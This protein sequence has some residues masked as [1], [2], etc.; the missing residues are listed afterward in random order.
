M[1]NR[2][3]SRRE[4]LNTSLLNK[5][6][7]G[8]SQYDRIAGYFSTSL[9]DISGEALDTINGNIR[10]ICNAHLQIGDVRNIKAYESA[11]RKDWC[12]SQPEKIDTKFP[13]RLNKLYQLLKTGK[14]EVKVLPD[15]IF[16][17]VHGKAGVITY[18][19]GNKTSFLGSM[20]ESQSG[21]ER[22]YE[23]VWEDDST[24]AV[25]W[26]QEEFNTLWNNEK[27][28]PLIDFIIEDIKRISERKIVY[29]IEQI[30]KPEETIVESP[31]Y[32]Q[33]L[34]LWEHQK[35]FI[36]LVY[37]TQLAGSKARYVLADMVGLGKTIQLG[38]SAQVLSLHSEKPVLIICPKTLVW[39]WQDEL[40]TLMGLPSA[41]W[42]GKCWV[43]ESG[44]IFGG[45]STNDIKRCPRK[46]GIISQ[47]IITANTDASKHL[48]D[49]EFNTVI[50]DECHRS[51]RKNLGKDKENERPEPNNLYAYL[52]K[53]AKKTEHMLMG[54]ATPIQLYPIEAWDLLN[55]LAQGDDKILGSYA[56]NWQ[57][58]PEMAL[59]LLSGAV[60]LRGNEEIFDWMRNPLPDSFED[61]QNIGILRESAGVEA[62][63]HILNKAYHE[64]SSLQQNIVERI[65]SNYIDEHNPFIRKIIRRTRKYLETTINP[66]TKEPYLA[67]IKVQLFGEKDLEAIVLPAYLRDAYAKAEEFSQELAKSKKN[68]KFITSLLLKRIGSSMYAGSMTAEKL[69]KGHK[70]NESEK[71]D[72]VTELSQEDDLFE[73]E[74][75]VQNDIEIDEK[76]YSALSE[77]VAIIKKQIDQDPKYNLLVDVLKD[78]EWV[79]RGC[80]IFSQYFDTAYWFA[81]KIV[82]QNVFP[83]E[84]IALYAGGDK[85]GMF[86]DGQ[87]V[88]R[89]KDE[90]KR[91]VKS[92]EIKILFGTDA[93]SEGLNLQTLGTLINIDLPW[94]PTRLEQ[95]KGRIQ[96]I[97]QRF[98]EVWIYNMRYKDSIEDRVHTILSERLKSITSIFGQ[99]PDVLED[100]WVEIAQ[101]NIEKAKK[102]ID[103]VPIQS[104]FEAK[105]ENPKM[106]KALK[107]DS[108]SKVIDEYI[109]VEHFKKSWGKSKE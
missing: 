89:P 49:L 68:S 95:R 77:F 56:S 58:I 94:N 92:G 45:K 52:L 59:K 79:K 93:A 101:N 72:N 48:T 103:A 44:N 3:S 102:I 38:L 61:P 88:K 32:R 43:D 66:E 78:K 21:W 14:L 2:F 24:E 70:K 65:S 18:S 11:L 97:G 25:S 105:Y 67:P 63:D 13:E 36:D 39:Q 90:L 23:L 37:R 19:D 31:V 76:A 20:N 86:I 64:L 74:I 100:V 71:L 53:I 30:S 47:G 15:E 82:K 27:A 54:T 17:F 99:L 83:N 106:I 87:F 98:D 34:G 4:K 29:Q 69:L 1:I 33:Q 55:I 75:V 46:I 85:S 96:R 10:I 51:R 22:N 108:C 104:P 5:K 57:N 35:Y 84:I 41:V 73:E 12:E 40:N 81:E 62:S 60:R 26:V 28:R 42:D 8:A 50:V 7:N 107:W 80:I 109:K 91:M 9:F 16:G 6:L